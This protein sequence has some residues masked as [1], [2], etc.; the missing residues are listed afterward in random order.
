M[1]LRSVVTPKESVL[2][3]WDVQKGLVRSIFNREEFLRGL[4]NVL[5]VARRTGIPTVFTKITPFPK[6]FEPFAMRAT[7]RRF[8]FTAE[9]LELEMSPKEGDI[10]ML[11]NTWS[12]FV[13]TNLELLLRNSGR[14]VILLTGIATEIGVETTARHAF[15]LGFLPVIVSDA[16]SSYNKEGHER[17][18][19]NMRQFFPVVSSMELRDLLG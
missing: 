11:K 10:V 7:G 5:E 16:V 9:D 8:Q 15:A 14:N 19:T 6:G 1:S 12:A 17:S 3:V 2:I 13:G 4:N 18:L